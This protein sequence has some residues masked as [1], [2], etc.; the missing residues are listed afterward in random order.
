MTAVLRDAA[1]G[2][3]TS[4]NRRIDAELCII[5]LC[6]PEASMDVQA[7]QARVSR[8]EEKLAA[9]VFAAPMREAP[10]A[11]QPPWEE[12]A[13]P[14]DDEGPPPIQDMSGQ[15]PAGFWAELVQR[16]R[17]SLK[18]P[19]FAMFTTAQNAPIHGSL[20]GN[21]LLLRAK[22]EWSLAMTDK[23]NVL[24]TVSEAAS[25]IVGQKITVKVELA[26]AEGQQN[27]GFDRLLSFGAEHP[28][29]VD[30]K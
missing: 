27:A 12:E 24:Q 2:F 15:E 29:L 17:A 11:E 30:F 23:P 21:V 20:R 18:P 22:D 26:G 10:R 25:A 28:E 19:A 9:G 1:A 3:N 13:P 5:R 8:L 6:E 4:A 16:V 7:L 14:P